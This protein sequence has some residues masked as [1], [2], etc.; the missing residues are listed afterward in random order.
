L[1]IAAALAILRPASCLANDATGFQWWS[2]AASK[3]DITS[4]WYTAVEE[5]FRLDDDSGLY[6]HHWD[7]GLGYSGLAEWV[8]LSFN[9]RQVYQED[10]DGEWRQENQP[11][12]NVTFADTFAG[13]ACSTRSRFEFRDRLGGED[14]W[15]YRNKVTFGLPWELAPLKLKPYL[16][17]EVFIDMDGEGYSRNR[18]SAGGVLAL[19]KGI[20]LDLYYLWQ[21]TR[22]DSGTDN[23]HAL[24]TKLVFLF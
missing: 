2:T 24:G 1:A 21:S 16:A 5:E 22:A 17:D 6:Y 3:V 9:F 14:N 23:I 8:D 15:R 7:V 10:D 20:K 4:D 13:I 19:A 11:H 18:F 12:V